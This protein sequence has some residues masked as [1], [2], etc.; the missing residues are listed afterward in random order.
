MIILLDTSTPVC[1]LTLVDGDNRY[2]YEW[3]SD[4][5]LAHGLLA[6]L[7]DK[8][9]EHKAGFDN[10]EAIGVMKGPGSF[11]GLRIG[12]TV[13]NTIASDRRI[14]I[15]GIENSDAW[16]EQALERLENDENDHLVMP[17]YGRDANITTPRK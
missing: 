13:L 9:A 4:R 6:F 11:T 16:R 5:E 3:Q 12:L 1:Y 17:H 2:D 14:P 8:L 7:S 10:I 15:V